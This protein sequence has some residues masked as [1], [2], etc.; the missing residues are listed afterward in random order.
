LE[1]PAQASLIGCRAR[2]HEGLKRLEE[3]A[4]M[5]HEPHD[6]LQ[7]ERIGEVDVARFIGEVV[8]T[9]QLAE[10]VGEELMTRLVGPGGGRMLVDFANVRSLSSLIIGKLIMLHQ[11]AQAAEGRLALCNLRPDV[12]E[13]MEI[14]RLTQVLAISAGEQEALQSF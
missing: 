14:M 11:A 7:I 3:Q 8:L 4:M 2:L 12:R 10:A 13:I 9:G 5:P 1:F 6:Y